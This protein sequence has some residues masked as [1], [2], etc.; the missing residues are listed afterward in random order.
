M[1]LN[2]D[3]TGGQGWYNS[4]IYGADAYWNSGY[5]SFAYDMDGDG[6]D[7]E[8]VAGSTIY[9]NDGSVFCELGGY[10]GTTW[11]PA[12]DGYPAVADML[13]FSGDSEGEPEI[14]L[15]GNNYVTVY[16]GSV[17]YDP[18]GLD[19]CVQITWIENKPE[20][21]PEISS[22]LPSHPDCN[23]TRYA[24]GGQPTVA[25][26]NGDG[27]LEIA[28]AGS[29][30]YSVYEFQTD[31][32]L[33]RYAVHPTRDWSSASTGSTVFDF[34]GDG[35]SE[36]VFSDEDAL[37]VWGIDTRSGLEP[38]Q[39]FIVYLEDD[40]HR[41]WT[42]HEYPLVADVD[43][44]GKAE[45]LS[46]NSPRPDYRD[47]YGFYVLG[48]SNDDWVSAR[49]IW[50]QH[51][52]YVTNIDDDQNIGY[53]EPNYRPYSSDD[54]NSFRQ[55]A[56]GTFGAKAAPNLYI[57]AEEPCQEG[58]GDI[59]VYVQVANEGAYI[60]ADSSI[61]LSL[62][63]V[64]GSNRTLI[65][66]QE[67][68]QPVSPGELTSGYKYELSGWDAYDYLVAVIDD[69][70]QSGTSDSWAKAKECDE[71]DNEVEISLDG[72]CP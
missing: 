16:H 14:V 72:L 32:S 13:R 55:Q 70:A 52:Y 21:D 35:A 59:T 36:V 3:T 63:G 5:H 15:T 40:N 47:H 11:I 4:D 51:A 33:S 8:L 30:W 10:Y 50:N 61:V 58:C 23:A 28:A 9:N 57:E 19:R 38:W 37:Y 2:F 39:R 22:S 62:Y 18:N 31:Q 64:V 24:F 67:I 42:I 68:A 44:D 25:D 1:T 65:D 20:D 43:G 7:M 41:S 17:D 69:P 26:F 53:A 6:S 46:V 71:G 66:S 29:C 45:I 27:D 56:P 54:Y 34:N 48:A 12:T 60:T 49:P